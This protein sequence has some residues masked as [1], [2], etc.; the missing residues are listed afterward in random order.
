MP[1]PRLSSTPK[2]PQQYRASNFVDIFNLV[3]SKVNGM[4]EGQKSAYHNATTSTPSGFSVGSY[5]LGDFVRNSNVTKISTSTLLASATCIVEGWICTNETTNVGAF[6]PVMT[7]LTQSTPGI[8]TSTSSG[9]SGWTLVSKASDETRTS[10][11]T[12]TADSALT[13][14]VS[15]NTNYRFR[16]S[17]FY[18]TNATPDFQYQLQG[19]A[20]PTRVRYEHHYIAPGTGSATFA[21]NSNYAVGTSPLGGTGPG[22]VAL[23]G[24]LQ[25]GV[26]AGSVS[27]QW[28]QNTSDG[29]PTLVLQ[30]SYIEWMVIA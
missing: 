3:D 4:A 13:F 27:F 20:S 17:I 14:A 5:A 21:N 1:K 16:M 25:N 15:A 30:G 22:H 23:E 24:I 10:T 18:D 2:V 7:L 28:A 6:E 29:N 19:P 9:S 12:M 11:T 8:G 26:N